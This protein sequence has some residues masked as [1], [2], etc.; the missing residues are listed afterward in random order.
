M[1]EHVNQLLELLRYVKY[2]RDDKVKIQH[3]LSVPPQSYKDRTNF[4]EPQTL[5]E[6]IRKKKYFYD[7]AKIRP[8]FH[9]AW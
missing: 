2:I 9:K 4:D 7:Q 3:F 6:T 8:K 5:D 1:E